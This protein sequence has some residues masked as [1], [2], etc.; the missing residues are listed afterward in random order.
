MRPTRRAGRKSSS[1]PSIAWLPTRRDP[2]RL[3]RLRQQ[4]RRQRDGAVGTKNSLAADTTNQRPSRFLPGT[5]HFSFGVDFANQTLH[6]PLSPDNSPTTTLNVNGARAAAGPPRPTKPNAPILPGQPALRLC[7]PA[8][9]R[10]MRGLLPG[11]DSERSRVQH[12]LLIAQHCL[13]RLH[14]G[15]V[16]RPRQLGVFR[17]VRRLRPGAM[18]RRTGRAEQLPAR[19]VDGAPTRTCPLLAPRRRLSGFLTKCEEIG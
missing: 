7:R 1:R 12:R 5:H 17:Y 8:Y 3:L 13:Q 14:G 6:W 18:W 4:E 10:R 16:A 2:D 19:P 15:C 9:V 11:A